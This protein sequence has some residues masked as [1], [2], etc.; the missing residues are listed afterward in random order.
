MNPYFVKGRL[1]V[2]PYMGSSYTLEDNRIVMSDSVQEAKTK[3]RE[4]WDEKS[5]SYG[6]SYYLESVY[7]ADTIT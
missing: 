6:T 3:Y 1:M 2:S 7:V 5:E 4:Y